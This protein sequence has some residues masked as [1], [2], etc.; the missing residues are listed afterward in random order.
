MAVFPATPLPFGKTQSPLRESLS[1]WSTLIGLAVECLVSPA[2]S[3][4]NPPSSESQGRSTF[5][6]PPSLTVRRNLVQPDAFDLRLT[7]SR[8]DEFGTGT[9][10][11]EGAGT[12]RLA[13][14]ENRRPCSTEAWDFLQRPK[15][16]HQPNVSAVSLRVAAQICTHQANISQRIGPPEPES[17]GRM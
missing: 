15:G 3:P 17:V 11:I 16:K 2:H 4:T 6:P 5:F 9:P 12:E 7:C 10:L 8:P 1:V 13:A 14:P